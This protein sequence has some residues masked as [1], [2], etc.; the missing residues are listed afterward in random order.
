MI[1]LRRVFLLIMLLAV[2][3][4][5]ALWL[6]LRSSLPQTTGT[7]PLP[8]LAAPVAVARDDRACRRFAPKTPMTSTWP[9]ASFTLRTDFFKWTCNAD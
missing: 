8:G 3:A 4:G 5:G 2:L 9:W 6:L 7:L 1:W